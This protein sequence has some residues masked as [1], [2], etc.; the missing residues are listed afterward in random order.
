MWSG[1]L[2]GAGPCDAQFEITGL[3]A[4]SHTIKWSAKTNGG[5]SACWVKNLSPAIITVWACRNPSSHRLCQPTCHNAPAI[6]RP[7]HNPPMER[8]NRAHEPTRP[9]GSAR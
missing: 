5:G 3:S 8:M 7:A 6:A 9:E 2:H 4:G 1:G